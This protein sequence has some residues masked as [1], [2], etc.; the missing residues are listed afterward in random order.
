MIRG[1]SAFGW[2]KGSSRQATRTNA[3]ITLALALG[4]GCG[5]WLAQ[6]GVPFLTAVV[7]TG[8]L[9]FAICQALDYLFDHKK[10]RRQ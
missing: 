7:L 8:P 4:V 3:F 6:Q 5:H 10:E 2:L 1:L 9:Y